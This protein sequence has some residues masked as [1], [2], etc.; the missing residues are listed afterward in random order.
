[1][2]NIGSRLP[3]CI[4]V[5]AIIAGM[6]ASYVNAADSPL[7]FKS[8]DKHITDPGSNLAKAR[9]K[10]RV[11]IQPASAQIPKRGNPITDPGTNG[12]TGGR[13]D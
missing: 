9:K 12:G 3:L 11:E 5:A 2:S 6:H 13:K 4:A 8:T 7:K 1:M 10:S